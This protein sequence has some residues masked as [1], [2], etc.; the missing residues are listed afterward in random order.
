MKL[1]K[2]LCIFLL[3]SL[4]HAAQAAATLDELVSRVRQEAGKDLR[5]DEERERRFIKE[6]NQQQA[7]LNSLRAELAEADKRADAFRAAYQENETRL[8]ELDGQIAAQAGELNDLFAMVQQNAAEVGSLLDRSLIS[9]QDP[10]R[11]A[12]LDKVIQRESAVSMETLQNLWLVLIDEMHETGKVARFTGPVITLEGEEKMQTVTRI[13]A[14][15]AVADGKFLR[16]LPDSHKLVELARQP[17]PRHQRMAQELEQAEDGWRTMAVDPSKGAIL[18]LLVQSPDLIER[19][20]QSGAIG[21]LILAIGV[22]GLL[23][24][25]W[26]GA[27]L[28]TAWRRIK[29]QLLEQENLDNNPLGRLRNS[30]ATVPARSSEILAARLDESVSQ[31]SSRLFFGLT[32]LTVFAAVTPLMGLLGTVIGMIETFQSISLFGTGDPKLMA[33]GISYALVTTQLGL[34][35]AIPLLLLQSFLHAQANRIVEILDQQSNRLFEQ[36]DQTLEP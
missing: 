15:N 7:R 35:V 3:V 9:A 21:Y 22:A 16:F 6:R 27:V 14:F 4:C 29:S 31:E 12:F 32:S 10:E 33:G 18:A 13:G 23:I 20:N 28:T 36:H 26:R 24:V 8:A 30:V 1:F 17:A 34:A 5:Y 2:L 19:I 25:L 11:G